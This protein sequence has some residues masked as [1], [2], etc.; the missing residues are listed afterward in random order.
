MSVMQ[1][2]NPS[3]SNQPI[4]WGGKKQ[5]GVTVA[6]R[7]AILGGGHGLSSPM[8]HSRNLPGEK[9]LVSTAGFEKMAAPWGLCA[10]IPT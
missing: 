6:L 8:R 5:E 7:V 3:V 9:V 4:T 2:G 1:E 10:N